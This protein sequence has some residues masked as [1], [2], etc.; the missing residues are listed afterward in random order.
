MK[1]VLFSCSEYEAHN[2]GMACHYTPLLYFINLSGRFLLGILSD[3]DKWYNDE[4]LYIADNRSKVTGVVHPGLQRK[5]TNKPTS[6]TL[7][8]RADF[9]RVVRKWHKKLGKVC[10]LKQLR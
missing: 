5:D 4:Q 10:N 6:D 2:Y 3:M 8:D 1:V 7:L 9:Q